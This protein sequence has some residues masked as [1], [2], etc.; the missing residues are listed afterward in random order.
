MLGVK[1][2]VK[3]Q[4]VSLDEII[5]EFALKKLNNVN[6]SNI[7]INAAKINRVGLQLAGFFESFPDKRIQIIGRGES[8]YIERLE[9]NYLR[10]V[11][12]RLL[13]LD[14]P[15]V[16]F[17]R[18]IEANQAFIK[19]GEEFGVPILGSDI[20]T[21]TFIVELFN[22]FDKRLAPEITLNGVLVDINGIG[23]FVRGKS[24]IGKSE[25]VLELIKRGHRIVADDSIIVK[26]HGDDILEGRSPNLIK[27]LMEIRGIGI[28]D[29]SKL[30]GIGSVLDSTKIDF[31]VQFEEYLE[32]REYDRLGIDSEYMEILGVKVPMV[33]VPVRQGRN[34]A[35]IL[36]ASARNFS[37]KAQGYNAALELNDKMREM[38]KKKQKNRE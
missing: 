5:E 17:T 29:I 6:T 31:V 24:G 9:E 36:E 10:Y 14:I 12:K 37:L 34:L 22:F 30:Y 8:V 23:T 38:R 21:S 3:K 33:I 16:I 1:S 7:F 20:S 28:V 25:A 2:A 13:K 35:V 27:N 32:G 11:A 18:G 4:E 19:Y 15:C 26:K